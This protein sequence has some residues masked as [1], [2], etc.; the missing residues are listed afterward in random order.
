VVIVDP[1]HGGPD[2]GSVGIGGLQEKGIVLDIGNQVALLLQ[3]YGVQAFV[4]RND[5]RD[6]DLEPRVQMAEQSQAAVFVSIHANAISLSRPDVSGL[7]TYY[8]QSGQELAQTIHQSILQTTGIAD[9]GVRTARFYVLRKTS[10]PSVLVE[11]GFVTGQ[12]DAMRLS[13]PAYRSQ[14]ADAIARG[15]LQYLQKTARL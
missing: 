10:M 6:L 15:I 4:T 14:M 12:D 8:Y 13:N 1:G 7:E 2:P 3:R 5:D 11:V 9:R